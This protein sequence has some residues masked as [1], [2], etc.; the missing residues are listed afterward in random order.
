MK[1]YLRHASV[2]YRN[3]HNNDLWLIRKKRIK[4]NGSLSPEPHFTIYNDKV[5]RVDFNESWQANE[6][7]I[8]L[9]Q[10]LT[11]KTAHTPFFAKEYDV[12]FAIG[13]WKRRGGMVINPLPEIVRQRGITLKH[14]GMLGECRT[15][16]DYQ[17]VERLANDKHIST[18][19]RDS[20][21]LAR[22]NQRLG[23]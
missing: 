7:N 11:N 14:L 6:R 17:R 4:R 5:G 15:P 21:T 1:L 8:F 10:H 2:V 16:L 23:L 12:L 20:F 3:N 13:L 22:I 9:L 19:D 18:A